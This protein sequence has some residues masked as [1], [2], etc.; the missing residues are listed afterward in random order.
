MNS[1]T[2]WLFFTLDRIIN[3]FQSI[4][5]FSV[6]YIV[7]TFLIWAIGCGVTNDENDKEKKK[8]KW[9]KDGFKKATKPYT[10]LVTV[11]LPVSLAL[12]TFLPN[13]KE[14]VAIVVI[15]KIVNHAVNNPELKKIPDN[16][17]KVANSFMEK[18]ITEWA[19]DMKLDLMTI[20]SS[21]IKSLDSTINFLSNKLEE[22]KK[23]KETT[24]KIMK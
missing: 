11:L 10:I 1:L 12:S 7:V 5:E 22:A 15:P 17:L 6:A 3:V 16:I 9:W 8:Q 18:K 19:K 4:F 13:T 21:K 2:L 14:A 23:L 20:D 24:E